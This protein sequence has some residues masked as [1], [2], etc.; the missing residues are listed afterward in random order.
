MS[1]EFGT[2]AGQTYLILGKATGWARNTS[3]SS[4]DASFIGEE[5]G[6]LSGLCVA[7]AGDVNGD[8]FAD[9]L[10]GATL[11]DEGGTNAGQTYLIL[12][13]ASD[14]TRDVRL[15]QADASFIGEAEFDESGC[16]AASAGDVNSDGFDDILIGAPFND[17]GGTN[18]G[19]TYLILGKASGWEMDTPLS[20]A[21][22]SLIGEGEDDFSGVAV[23]GV[24]DVN[25]DSAADILIGASGNSTSAGQ[26]YLFLGEAPPTPTPLPVPLGGI[27]VLIEP[28]RETTITSPTG[29]VMVVVPQGAVAERGNL[30]FKP[31]SLE[32][33]PPPPQDMTRLKSF[34]LTFLDSEGEAQ[35]VDFLKEITVQVIYTAGDLASIAGNATSFNILK[36]NVPNSVW[37]SLRTSLDAANKTLSTR[38]SRLSLFALG[39][40]ALPIPS[41]TPTPAPTETPTPEPPAPTATPTPTLTPIPPTSTPTF[42]PTPTVTPLLPS[43]TPPLPPISS[44]TP[45]PT[46]TPVSLTTTPTPTPT[47]TPPLPRS[48]PSP[49]ATP[50]PTQVVSPVTPTPTPFTR[51]SPVPP[52]PTATATPV[53]PIPTPTPI[54]GGGGGLGVLSYIIIAIVVVVVVI[55]GVNLLRGRGG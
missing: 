29:D 39:G 49:T 24:G 21:D 53:L 37:V 15:S 42:T 30:E 41:P 44:P 31:V 17:E 9:I 40:P 18:A 3:L 5:Q 34:E 50:T 48:T 33:A 43:P 6:D 25:S 20:Q 7:S 23:A 4:A 45:T 51:P 11:N 27:I 32:T 28:D 8:G 14:W 1:D 26:T 16:P 36:Y 55:L 22:A 38:I 2:D 52:T 19:K 13:K 54:P 10:I 47:P 46:S 12:G 35:E